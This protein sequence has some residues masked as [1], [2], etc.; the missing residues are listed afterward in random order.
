MASQLNKLVSEFGRY[1]QE[2]RVRNTGCGVFRDGKT[3]T[4]NV[5]Y[6]SSQFD[7]TPNDWFRLERGHFEQARTA[8][9]KTDYRRETEDPKRKLGPSGPSLL[10]PGLFTEHPGKTMAGTILVN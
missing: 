3:I 7:M 5:R 6:I 10:T 4:Y 2:K 9:G 8:Q 1:L